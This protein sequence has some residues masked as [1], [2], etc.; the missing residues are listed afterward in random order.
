[1][2][3]RSFLAV[4]RDEYETY[5]EDLTKNLRA[6]LAVSYGRTATPSNEG[7]GL[8]L[9]A[10]GYGLTGGW[11][12][13]QKGLGAGGTS[14]QTVQ[15]DVRLD[16]LLADVLLHPDDPA[17]DEWAA[18]YGY[19][20]AGALGRAFRDRY[21]VGLGHVRRVEVVGQWLALTSRSPRSAP[22]RARREEAEARVAELR[23]RLR[24][25]RK[26]PAASK[27]LRIFTSRGHLL[28]STARP[29]YPLRGRSE[30][31]PITGDLT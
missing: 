30:Q 10:A 9:A 24:P 12:S 22:G 31:I 3:S 29:R 25:R 18:R 16:M 6:L 13:L 5:G 21:D 20:S 2:V 1:L 7:Y 17:T 8:S 15:S 14:F 26:G 27:A 19:A 4:T 11:W 28:P 23:R